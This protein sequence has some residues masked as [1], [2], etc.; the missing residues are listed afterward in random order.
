MT[1]SIISEHTVLMC[2]VLF[3]F[4]PTVLSHNRVQGYL[5]Q[6]PFCPLLSVRLCQTPVTQLNSVVRDYILSQIVALLLFLFFV[7]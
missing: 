1:N 2:T 5:G 4:S 3:V 7:H 6:F